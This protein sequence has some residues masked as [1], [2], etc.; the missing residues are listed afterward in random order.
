MATLAGAT[1]MISRVEIWEL[2]WRRWAVQE[3]LKERNQ[4]GCSKHADKE[5]EQ[6]R[7]EFKIHV[8]RVLLWFLKGCGA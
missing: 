1:L 3:M 7:E 6:E 4:I 2:Q 8:L 5:D